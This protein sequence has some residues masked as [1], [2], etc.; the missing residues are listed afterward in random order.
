VSS[1]VECVSFENNHCTDYGL[2]G[3]NDT[4]KAVESA[5]LLY[6]TDTKTMYLEKEGYKIAVI[7]CGLWSEWQTEQI[8]ERI[9]DEQDKSD[10]QVIYFHGG[11]ERLHEPEDWKVRA[12]HRMVDNG[13]DLVIGGHP[14]VLQ[15]RE[16]YNNV[17]IVYSLGN[18][19]YGG[20]RY[21]E[22]R[23]IIYQ[24]KLEIDEN[25]EIVKF[26]SEII[27]CYVYTGERNNYQPDIIEDKNERNKVLE[28][29]E[30]KTALPY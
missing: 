25:K 12:C 9:K 11:T 18:F 10:Y 19:C 4:I 13:A 24:A 14:H 27:P 16:T 22:N 23:T 29:M 1:S 6:G 28:F 26:E 30:G 2:Q 20:N 15:P 8:I 5:N 21:P 7:C 17:E 3:Y